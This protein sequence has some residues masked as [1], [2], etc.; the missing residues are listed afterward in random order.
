MDKWVGSKRQR[1]RQ[2]GRCKDRQ[3]DRQRNGIMDEG[4]GG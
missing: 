3:T 2:A 4:M 1:K